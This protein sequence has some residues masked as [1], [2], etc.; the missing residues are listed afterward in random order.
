MSTPSRVKVDCRNTPSESNCSLAISGT[1]E[2]V[3]EA[4]VQHAKSK[5]GHEDSAE[6]REWIRSSW[7][8]DPS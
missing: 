4:A 5:H 7:M 1:P 3:L 8:E 6:L 2:E